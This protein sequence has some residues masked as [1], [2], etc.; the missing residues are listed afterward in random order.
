VPLTESVRGAQRDRARDPFTRLMPQE[1][2]ATLAKP[3]PRLCVRV[4]QRMDALVA[5]YND[6]LVP[7]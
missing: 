5:E 4:F 1:P 6:R 2:V 3:L 7:V